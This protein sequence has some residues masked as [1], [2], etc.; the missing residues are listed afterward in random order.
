M[1]P[2]GAW[3][4]ILP[5]TV[6]RE[7]PRTGASSVIPV[8]DGDDVRVA[9]KETRHLDG[10]IVC[11]TAAVHEVC[12]VETGRHLAREFLG[13]Q[14]DIRMEIGIRERAWYS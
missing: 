7:P 5:A 10:E 2:R 9:G 13:E 6:R 12:H 1:Y 14:G 4:R 11:F 3:E 8:P